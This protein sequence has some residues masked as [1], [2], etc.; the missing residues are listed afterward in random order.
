MRSHKRWRKL[1]TGLLVFFIIFF[2]FLFFTL[3][4]P[5]SR[6]YGHKT[7]L[8]A[9]AGKTFDAAKKQN[10]DALDK[11]ILALQQELRATEQDVQ[12]VYMYKHV[13]LVGYIFGDLEHGLAAGD[14]LLS[15]GK[16]A[17][18]A[19]EPYA[20]L[21]GF[22]KGSQFSNQSTEKRLETAILT[23][24]KLVPQIDKISVDLE[25][26]REDLEAIDPNRYPKQIGRYVIRERVQNIHEQITGFV[27]LATDAKPLFKQLPKILGKDE[28]QQYLVL[29]LNDKELRATGGFITAYAVFAIDQGQLRVKESSDIYDLDNTISHPA[30]PDEILRYHKDVSRFYI[31]DSNLSP[32][33]LKSIGYF[34]DLMKRSSKNLTYDGI[35]SIDTE[36][37]TSTLAILGPTEAGG[38]TFT[39]DIDER[40]DCPQV[41][42]EL[43]NIITRPTPYFREQRK[44]ILSALLYNI[45]QKALGVSPSQYWGRLSQNFLTEL[46][47]KHM[48]V[49]LK[50]KEAQ[51][52]IESIGYGGRI[53]DYAGD[54]L[55][56]NNTNFAGAKSNMYIS[57]KL[58]SSAKKSGDV[59]EREVTLEYRNN[60][61]A[62]DCNLERGTLCL[63]APLRNWVRVYVPEGAKLIKFVGS[64]M[65]VRQY[66]DLNKQVFEGFLI[67]KPMGIAQIKLTY[68]VPAKV[69]REGTY[70]LLLQ[71]QPGVGSM[72]VTVQYDNATWS[73]LVKRDTVI[74]L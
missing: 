52:A 46:D 30:A 62:S 34:E 7:K 73:Q 55:H 69:L 27:S 29:F 41:I 21:I 31:R 18:V 6:A 48:L 72:E 74:S 65:P 39:A 8:Q 70:Q 11:Q 49:Y 22:K 13:P 53:K 64:E 10:L 50:D 67:I 36:V 51:S 66:T 40:C 23:I 54:Y 58:T 71:K 12:P 37:L 43:E 9:L 16:K 47:E 63:N 59:I 35:I 15:A 33:Y 32:D 19:L 42:Y 28:E 17:V 57:Y 5:L 24:D 45:M 68:Q 14:A 60:H 20:D 2:T 61:P 1:S 56:I 4:L 44:S 26:A 25:K 38:V 3:F